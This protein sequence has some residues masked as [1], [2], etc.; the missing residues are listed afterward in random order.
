MEFDWIDVVVKLLIGLGQ[1][2]YAL[3]LI[4]LSIKFHLYL[5]ERYKKLFFRDEMVESFSWL[6]SAEPMEMD[7]ICRHAA[8]VFGASVYQ[9]MVFIGILHLM[10]NMQ[11]PFG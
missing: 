3:I 8:I 11:T 10:A 9:G 5:M 6:K 2:G 7:R 4:W 1:F